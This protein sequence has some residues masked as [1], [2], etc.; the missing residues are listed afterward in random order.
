MN[1]DFLDKSGTKQ[2][3]N[4]IKS[5]IDPDSIASAS[6][7]TYVSDDENRKYILTS[8]FKNLTDEQKEML[9]DE[10]K[11]E[12]VIVNEM[13]RV[14]EDFINF[15]DR[16]SM[17]DFLYKLMVN[18]S[19][20]NSKLKIFNLLYINYPSHALNFIYESEGYK[21]EL[22]QLCISSNLERGYICSLLS[23]T[24]VEISKKLSSKKLIDE[25]NI[26]QSFSKDLILHKVFADYK[27]VNSLTKEI[28]NR[29]GNQEF[30]TFYTLARNMEKFKYNEF[31][32]YKK[33]IELLRWAIDITDNVEDTDFMVKANRK[34]LESYS[35]S[36]LIYLSLNFIQLD[37]LKQKLSIMILNYI[38]GKEDLTREQCFEIAEKVSICIEEYENYRDDL[39]SILGDLETT[40]GFYNIMELVEGEGFDLI[41]KESFKLYIDQVIAHTKEFKWLSKMV[42]SKKYEEHNKGL[43]S[44]A[45]TFGLMKITP[46]GNY[47]L[48]KLLKE[49]DKDLYLL[50]MRN[51]EE[52]IAN[53]IGD[54]ERYI[55]LMIAL[56]Y[57]SE[58]EDV[59][60]IVKEYEYENPGTIK[61]FIKVCDPDALE[62]Y[63]IQ[64][65]KESISKNE[66]NYIN[67]LKEI[68]EAE[69]KNKCSSLVLDHLIIKDFDELV[70]IWDNLTLD[71]GSIIRFKEKVLKMISSREIQL[72]KKNIAFLN[73]IGIEPA[74]LYN[75]IEDEDNKLHLLDIW[76][77]F[78]EFG[79][80]ANIVREEIITNAQSLE[81]LKD[82]LN[83]LESYQISDSNIDLL[84]QIKAY[85]LISMELL[86]LDIISEDSIDRLDELVNE[87]IYYGLI[88]RFL[89]DKFL[90]QKINKKV[91]DYIFRSFLDNVQSNELLGYYWDNINEEMKGGHD[92]LDYEKLEIFLSH[93]AKSKK[94]IEWFLDSFD[95][96]NMEYDIFV[97][98]IETLLILVNKQNRIIL[99]NQLELD[100]VEEKVLNDIGKVIGK[101]LSNMEKTIANRTRDLEND[102]LVEN[103]KKFR[104][105]LK[106]AGIGTVEDI[107][108]Y[109]KHVE[110]DNNLHENM[111]LND[112]DG[113][114]VDSLGIEVNGKSVLLSTLFNI[115]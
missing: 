89:M 87:L 9:I 10:I 16:K 35:T 36:W 78:N 11:D 104:K 66:N 71:I 101:S 70:S 22:C 49:N 68:E 76:H 48:L 24:N 8:H 29:I 67:L 20:K 113:G 90:Q 84:I 1:L 96:K 59:F 106:K 39:L 52:I 14:F 47:E 63:Y 30:Q 108:N 13:I 58:N 102:I 7:R 98:I 107:E 6:V 85:S 53:S 18:V 25:I 21:K 38:L 4:A 45:L 91:V 95:K 19:D 60:N 109:G 105:E 32:V 56:G 65:I 92:N 41:K 69:I 3:S 46:R 33:D 61:S 2:F 82:I 72:T 103:L 75:S 88:D 57:H 83:L 55:I 40:V 86:D 100:N 27:D 73:G 112:L 93:L 37:E 42:R 12:I 26:F 5:I 94:S 15:D 80:I 23:N 81:D 51:I 62:K 44:K 115:D 43:N 54:F 31:D 110:F 97:S 17:A 79:K 74:V 64:Q 34:N 99:Q 114:W 77:R 111:Q 50:L 28:N